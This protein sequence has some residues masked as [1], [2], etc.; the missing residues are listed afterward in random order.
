[1]RATL[2]EFRARSEDDMMAALALYRPGPLRGG[3][4][5]AWRYSVSGTNPSYSQWDAGFDLAETG[6][7]R[8]EHVDTGKRVQ[9]LKQKFILHA[10][11]RIPRY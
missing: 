2:Q 4:K 6:L 3:L 8:R 1:M 7:L 10:N 9:E 5:D 11:D